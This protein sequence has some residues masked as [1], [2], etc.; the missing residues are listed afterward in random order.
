M[1]VFVITLLSIGTLILVGSI[2]AGITTFTPE[3]AQA[4]RQAEADVE[5]KKVV[6]EI[7]HLRISHPEIHKLARLDR[8]PAYLLVICALWVFGCNLFL[9]DTASSSNIAHL[10][11]S[12]QHALAVCLLVGTSL[13]LMGSFSGVKV[14]PW[15]FGRPVRAHLLAPM[16][17]DDIRVPYIIGCAGLASTFFSMVFYV[18]STPRGRLLGTLGGVLGLAAVGICLSL[19]VLFSLCIRKYVEARDM[20]LREYLTEI[21][22]GTHDFE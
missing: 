9:G 15:V 13:C 10:S 7:S 2:I 1:N 12:I 21:E 20:L 17:G 3:R 18:A 16:L 19:G 8:H 14:G 22:Q 5:A 4:V 11:D 6:Q